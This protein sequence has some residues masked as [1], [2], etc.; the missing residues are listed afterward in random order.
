MRVKVIK[1][2]PFTKNGELLE[3]THDGS[4]QIMT[5]NGCFKITKPI[6]LQMI[7]EGY[8][9]YYEEKTLA[10]ELALNDIEYQ[11]NKKFWDLRAKIAQDY[12][13]KKFIEIFDKTVEE[14][15]K[16]GW[17]ISAVLHFIRYKLV[18]INYNK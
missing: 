1:E 5:K 16:Y 7:E 4:I 14:T 2:I 10:Q 17:K 15:S 11:E 9:E 12:K 13:K 6:V 8:L 3:I 18:N